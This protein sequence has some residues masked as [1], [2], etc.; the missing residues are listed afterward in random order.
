MTDV[1]RN[2]PGQGNHGGMFPSSRRHATKIWI[3]PC[4]RSCFCFLLGSALLSAHPLMMMTSPS[5]G[6][7]GVARSPSIH[8]YRSGRRSFGLM[9]LINLHPLL[10]RLT[11]QPFRH[12]LLCLF[13]HAGSVSRA[14][15]SRR[16]IAFSLLLASGS[17]DLGRS[18]PSLRHGALTPDTGGMLGNL[19]TSHLLLKRWF[20]FPRSSDRPRRTAYTVQ[21]FS[22][23]EPRSSLP[24][25][26]LLG[27]AVVV[28]RRRLMKVS[29]R[30]IKLST[31]PRL[32][33]CSHD[34]RCNY[35][36]LPPPYI[37]HP[38]PLGRSM[39]LGVKATVLPCLRCLRRTLK[40]LTASAMY[41]HLTVLEHHATAQ[42]N[43]PAFKLPHVSTHGGSSPSVEA[44]IPVNYRRFRDDVEHFG[45]YW[46]ATFQRAGIAP[47]SCI[48]I[49]W[50]FSSHT[51]PAVG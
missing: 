49:W 13:Y 19:C 47:R 30:I 6:P 40:L 34:L 26:V 25:E 35:R 48:G 1:F 38:S 16:C 4:S 51:Y 7:A 20:R 12:A 2:C 11:T 37:T 3:V 17:M 46:T 45:R 5:E 10:G 33:L 15:I 8:G 41:S 36:C 39:C 43:T 32:L 9:V 42:A 21:R 28:H 27:P 23:T 31:V 22:L 18:S 14:T 24:F 29:F 50:V 44:W